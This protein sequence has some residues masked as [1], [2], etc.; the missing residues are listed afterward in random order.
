MKRVSL[1]LRLFVAAAVAGTGSLQTPARAQTTDGPRR[2][3]SVITLDP[4]NVTARKI[5]EAQ[6]DV[7]I[8]ITVLGEQAR[9]ERRIDDVESV[10]RQVPGVGFSA[11]GDGRSTFLSI[12]GIG[13]ISQPL[14]YDDT[15]TVT[16]VDGVPQPLFG[17]DLAI[18][19]AERIEVMRGPQGTVF[20]RNARPA[21]S[22]SSRDG[23]AIRPR[24][25]LAAS[26]APTGT[27]LA[28]ARS[29]DP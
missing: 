5:E 29:P 3:V 7:P 12:R 18:L 16:Y 11:V 13:P 1:T 19:D 2:D 25:P 27:A 21:R 20:G 15:S 23:P 9:Q 17:S 6:Q 8:S 10:L 28:T 4:V 24:S 14:G 26:S 22:T